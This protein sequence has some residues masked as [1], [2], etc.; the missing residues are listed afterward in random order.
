MDSRG[1]TTYSQ[2]ASEL[3][4]RACHERQNG[5]W[6]RENDET[7]TSCWG[8][9]GSNGVNHP[10]LSR[11]RMVALSPRAKRPVSAVASTGVGVSRM[12]HPRYLTVLRDLLQPAVGVQSRLDSRM[13][14]SK[15]P[16]MSDTEKVLNRAR[17]RTPMPFRT[18]RGP[19][20]GKIRPCAGLP[21]PLAARCAVSFAAPKGRT[22][23]A[24][25]GREAPTSMRCSFFFA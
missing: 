9:I 3:L 14:D 16:H 10:L 20:S 21:R 4:T 22:S 12:R 19:L 6:R 2:G 11:M 13:S 7:L 18:P 23:G 17:D 24:H 5:A 1:G 8:R 15:V 25:H